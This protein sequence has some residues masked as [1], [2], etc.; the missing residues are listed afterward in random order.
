MVDRTGP[1]P[2]LVSLRR[3]LEKIDRAIVLLVAARVDAACSAIRLRSQKEGR[4]AD[5]AQEERVIVRAKEWADQLGVSTTLTETIFRA[6]V[7]SG[8]EK[9]VRSSAASPVP[10]VRLHGSGRVHGKVPAHR[11]LPPLVRARAAATT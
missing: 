10:A 1:D 7:E 5:P 2:S 9:F 6:I 8:K 4:V 3:D 11:P